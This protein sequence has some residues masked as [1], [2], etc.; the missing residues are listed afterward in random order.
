MACWLPTFGEGADM[1]DGSRRCTLGATATTPII[2]TAAVAV[3]ARPRF[4]G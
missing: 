3:V 2:T 1:A 4:T